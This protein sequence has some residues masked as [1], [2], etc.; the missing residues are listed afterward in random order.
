MLTVFGAGILIGAALNVII[1]EG[2]H[3]WAAALEQLEEEAHTQSGAEHHAE[4]TGH[5]EHHH[6]HAENWQIGTAL[7]VGFAFMLVVDRLSGDFG[8]SHS[9]SS[10]AA[11][12]APL[13]EEPTKS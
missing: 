10:S 3:M 2:L 11:S 4:H 9:S 12:A 13:G 8:H 7:S 5:E 6:E 1:P